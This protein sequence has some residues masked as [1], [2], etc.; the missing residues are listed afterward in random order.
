[1]NN[2]EKNYS[3]SI[4]AAYVFIGKVSAFLFSFVIPV[5]LVRIFTKEE[6]GTYQQTLLISMTF[7]EI[8][9]W[10]FANSLF[11]FFSIAKNKL[12]ALLSQTFFALTTIGV[13]LL[14]LIYLMRYLIASIFNSE[15]F[16]SLIFPIMVYFF[17]MLNSVILNS[18]FILEK[19]SKI[20]IVYEILNQTVRAFLLVGSS[21][22]FRNIY[23]TI[24][25]LSGFAFL[26]SL[27][28]FIYINKN[29]NISFLK[30]DLPFLKSQI[31]YCLPIGASR[32]LGEI[33]GKFDKYLLSAFLTPADYAV[34]AIA[35]LKIPLIRLLYTS[36]G[37]VVVPKMT[38]YSHSNMIQKTKE[39][40]HK[41][42]IK[43]AAVT[44]PA[45]IFLYYLADDIIVFLFTKDYIASVIIFKIFL[46]IYMKQM[47]NPSVILRACNQ[48]GAIF[49]SHLIS[50]F[51]TVF[52]GYILI[53]NYGMLGGA[54]SV[55]IANY[56]RL[57]IRLVKV[58]E[59]LQLQIPDLLPWRDLI[60]ILFY[61]ML[62]GAVVFFVSSGDLNP[63][64]NI[65]ASG[66]VYLVLIMLLSLYYKYIELSQIKSIVKSFYKPR[67]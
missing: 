8:F 7:V 22:V 31:K 56:T 59:I 44:I 3:L 38:D 21:L 40:W 1:M 48:P 55:V 53:R 32:F 57:V 60:R 41:M 28:L 17:F 26:R 6:Y 10:G 12:S 4:Q 5:I 13:C 65:A 35:N 39:L 27:F 67:P 54:I 50:M 64:Q 51:V 52:F 33:G 30:I 15:I 9:K 62:S 16:L 18:I 36:I 66:S 29:Y 34:Y 42:I 45:V 46:L 63:I 2:G 49:S 25:S 47:I 11:Y 43:Y 19:K 23:I 20:V 61:S 24:W 14:P 58:K 37:N